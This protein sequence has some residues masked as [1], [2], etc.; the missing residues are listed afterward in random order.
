MSLT[1]TADDLEAFRRPLTG[2]C[3]RML[4]SGSE[5]EDAVQETMIKAWRNLERFEGRSSLKSWIYRIATNVCLDM[6]KGPQRRA[7]PMDLGPSSTADSGLAAPLPE[8]AW[9]QPI[10]DAAVFGGGVF[11][12]RVLG[13]AGDPAQAVEGRET[14][15]LAF[16]AALQHLPARQRAALILCE[17]FKWSAAEAAALLE[18]SVASIN[19]S[20]Q[21]ARATLDSLSGLDAMPL[22]EDDRQL[23]DDFVTA[24][25]TYDLELMAS[26][27]R[28]DVEFSMPPFELWLRGPEQVEAWLVGTG[29]VCQG[30]KLVA[31]AA[32]GGVA[33]ACYHPDPAGGW[34]PWSIQLLETRD[35]RISGW[36]NFLGGELFAHFGVPARLAADGSPVA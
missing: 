13:A 24:F 31:T 27:L 7:R 16:V 15:R 18:T 26:L 9:V 20:L 4:G 1:P 36:H 29:A 3:Y 19:S 33:F 22:T 5:A 32:N 23:V 6:R 11:G 21:R 35:G 12:G 30:S 34:A 2:Y 17:V 8:T 14:L 28:D 10:A 25:E